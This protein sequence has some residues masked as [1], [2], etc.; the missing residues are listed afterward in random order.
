MISSGLA[1]LSDTGL[2]RVV[3]AMTASP[4]AI[5][6]CS[7]DFIPNP[8]NVPDSILSSAFVRSVNGPTRYPNTHLPMWCPRPRHRSNGTFPSDPTVSKLSIVV[9]CPIIQAMVL[10][11]G[12][13]CIWQLNSSSFLSVLT[14]PPTSPTALW[15]NFHFHCDHQAQIFPRKLRILSFLHILL[16]RRPASQLVLHR[17]VWSPVSIQARPPTVPASQLHAGPLLPFFQRRVQRSFLFVDVSRP[18]S[19]WHL[20]SDRQNQCTQADIGHRAPDASDVDVRDPSQPHNA[21]TNP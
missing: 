7:L 13:I 17:C 10:D 3:R 5:K 21:C 11:S 8:T 1:H 16:L 6:L 12:G 4:F 9:A 2:L 18:A 19:V 15:A 14:M 20:R